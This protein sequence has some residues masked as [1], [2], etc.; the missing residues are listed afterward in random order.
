MSLKP[1]PED[2]YHG[3][4]GPYKRPPRILERIAERLGDSSEEESRGQV[5]RRN[6][7][8]SLTEARFTPAQVRELNKALNESKNKG[9]I[10]E[11]K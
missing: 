6:K 1:D 2:A 9:E 10:S 5:L 3:P 11:E 7:Q 8:G 4:R